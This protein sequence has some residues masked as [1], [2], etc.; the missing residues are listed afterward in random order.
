MN[1][2]NNLVNSGSDFIA[3]SANTPHIVFDDLK[4]KS[5]VPLVSIIEAARDEAVRL[6]MRKLGLFGTSFTMAGEFFKKPFYDSDI[7]I[8]IPTE[9]E[10]EF[11]NKKITSELELGV[12]KEET[13]QAFQEIIVRMKRESEIEAIILGC[14]ELP[15]LL[16]DAVSA[17][18]CLDTMKIHIK[19]LIDMITE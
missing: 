4:E 8:V 18:P 16:N 2:I 10:M 3:L 7:E 13:L 11:I 14:T 6:N 9:E 17:V 5:T 19:S 12:V 15:L 1:A